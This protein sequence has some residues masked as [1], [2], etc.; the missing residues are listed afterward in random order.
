MRKHLLTRPVQA[1]L[2]ACTALVAIL[3]LQ[4]VFPAAPSA[5]IANALADQGTALPDFEIPEFN[6][7]AMAELSDMMQRPLFFSDRVMPEPPKDEAP[8]P[9][10]K[11]LQLKLLGVAMGGTARVAVLRNLS[12]NLLLNLPEGGSHEG[13]TLDSVNS[14]SARFSRGEQTTEL[15]LDP[16]S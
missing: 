7:P 15:L 6:P 12:N 4:L 3:A 2:A 5:A 16:D 14:T 8:A 9:P 11:P 1:L 10:P 13:W